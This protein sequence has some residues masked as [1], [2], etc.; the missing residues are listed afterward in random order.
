MRTLT[1]PTERRPVSLT[2]EVAAYPFDTS[3]IL[4]DMIR[5]YSSHGRAQN[6]SFRK[7]V[8]WMKVGERGTHYIHSYPGKLLPQ[9][10]HF[11]LAANVLTRPQ[12][13]V[14]DPFGGTGTVALETV[15]AGRR[16]CYAD[17]NPLAALVAKVKTRRIENGVID[18]AL[19]RVRA[20]CMSAGNGLA[21]C[22]S[23][24]NIAY[25]YDKRA[26][27]VLS[28]LKAAIE[29]ERRQDVR[30]F[31]RIAFSTTCR[32]VSKADPR[33]S[34]PVLKKLGTDEPTSQEIWQVF[35]D[36][37]TANSARMSELSS[38]C[39]NDPVVYYVGNNARD[40]RQPT[41]DFSLSQRKLKANSVALVLTSPPYAS[42]QKY[43]RA[44]SLSLG[45]LGL[46]SSD[47][48]K[49]LENA[50][51]GRE[52]FPKESYEEIP[53]TP[54]DVADGIIKRIFK[55]NPL[56]AAIA[57]SYLT[58]MSE[59]LKEIV[60]V[61]RPGGHLVLVIGNNQVCGLPFKSSEYLRELCE[62]NGLR[63][64][65]KLIDEIKSRG[66]MTKRNRTASVITREWVLVLQKPA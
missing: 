10:A 12:D 8:P 14:L 6:V 43:V 2:K 23:V 45:W 51:I 47:E 29:K 34:V 16:A 15:L 38:L 33:L 63:V 61:L 42:A 44:S 53:S 65:L 24:V 49:T 36:Q 60:R 56:R 3:P 4:N 41:A 58:E 62:M 35:E 32:K 59:A 7:L 37:V 52:H 27:A 39:Q 54:F 28:R 25:W 48:L 26:I 31:L 9:I 30:D 19:R 20:R 40:L 18:G 64:V 55:V 22:P 13:L 46:V 17:V 50:T 57:A 5:R 1:S 21:R 11:F 66:L